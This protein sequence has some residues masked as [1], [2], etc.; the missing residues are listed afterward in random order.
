MKEPG[1]KIALAPVAGRFGRV[2]ATA[3]RDG[4]RPIG[5]GNDARASLWDRS[6]ESKGEWQ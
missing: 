3:R 2:D 1:L 5:A 4:D 6:D